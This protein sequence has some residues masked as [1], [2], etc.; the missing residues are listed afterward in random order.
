MDT[1][2]ARTQTAFPARDACCSLTADLWIIFG[3]FLGQNSRQSLDAKRKG[4][5]NRESGSCGY[6]VDRCY[7]PAAAERF[8]LNFYSDKNYATRIVNLETAAGRSLPNT[9]KPPPVLASTLRP[10]TAAA[11]FTTPSVGEVR[12]RSV[13]SSANSL[14]FSLALAR[15]PRRP[16]ADLANARLMGFRLG[17]RS[18]QNA[19]PGSGV[20]SPTAPAKRARKTPS[21]AGVSRGGQNATPVAE[22]SKKQRKKRSDAG[23]RRGPR[24]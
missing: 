21:D 6:V 13:W 17:S 23:V 12:A 24:A 14:R 10:T 22:G 9:A 3:S 15:P 1:S 20:N 18:C 11:P 7:P 8:T 2:Q 16:R 4:H 19:V 5:P